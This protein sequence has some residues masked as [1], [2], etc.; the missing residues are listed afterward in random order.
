MRASNLAHKR[1]G[2]AIA[3]SNEVWQLVSIMVPVA[4]GI[5]FSATGS[6]RIALLT[7]A[8]DPLMAAVLTIFVR[9]EPES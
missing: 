7:Q 5:V 9:Y 8:A 3:I 2:T 6:F 1:T 4:I